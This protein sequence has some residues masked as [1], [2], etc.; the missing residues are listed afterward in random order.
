M[1]TH[2]D[3]VMSGG[4]AGRVGLRDCPTSVNDSTS[5]LALQ[6][7]SRD[8]TPMTPRA[9]HFASLVRQETSQ[10]PFTRRRFK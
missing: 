7:T 5:V 6:D 3:E 1:R 10:A 9:Q 2:S 4:T 8:D